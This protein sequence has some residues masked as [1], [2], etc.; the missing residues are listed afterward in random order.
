[1]VL[2]EVNRL[3]GVLDKQLNDGRQFIC[4]EQ[5]TIADIACWPW[6]RTYEAFYNAKHLIDYEKYPNVAKWLHRCMEREA[7]KKALQGT[8]DND[9]SCSSSLSVFCSAERSLLLIRVHAVTQFPKK[10]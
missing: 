2:Q 10:E 4:G 1:M 6:V 7:S 8:S 3:L 5:Y 9:C